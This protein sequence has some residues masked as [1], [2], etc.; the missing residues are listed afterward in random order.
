MATYLAIPT[1]VTGHALVMK[2]KKERMEADQG[3]RGNL[4]R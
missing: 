1:W 2:E 4:L 3:V